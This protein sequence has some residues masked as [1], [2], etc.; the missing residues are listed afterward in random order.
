MSDEDFAALIDRLRAAAAEWFND[1]R[2]L[3]LEALIRE[4]QRTRAG[5]T[6]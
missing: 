3:D 5:R 6:E 1:K 4:C 2:L